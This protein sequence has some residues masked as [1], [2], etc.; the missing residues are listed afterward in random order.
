MIEPTPKIHQSNTPKAI[1]LLTSSLQTELFKKIDEGYLYW[2][3][4]KYLAPK[5]VAP[6]ILWHAVKLKRSMNQISLSIKGLTFHFTITGKMQQLL[7]EFDMEFGGNLGS[8]SIIPEKNQQVYLVNSIMEEAIA[9]SQME[10]ASTTRK[11][12]KDMLRKQTKP[13]GKS[14]QMIVNNYTTIKYLVEHKE[15]LFSIDS[16]LNVHRLISNKTLNSPAEEGTIRKDNEVRVVNDITGEVVHTPPSFN[17]L[18]DLLQGLCDFANATDNPPFIHPIIKG[19]IIHFMLAY[20]HPFSDGNGRTA[21]SLFYWYMLKEGYWLTEYI[22]ISRSIYKSKSQY[23]KSFLYAEQDD[24]DIS[25]FIKYHLD[26]MKK[27]Y[28]DLKG[29][30]QKKIKEQQEFYTFRAFSNINERQAEI[31]RIFTEK[32]QIILT[33]KECSNRFPVSVKTARADLQHL[34]QLGLLRETPINK[35]LFGYAKSSDFDEIFKSL[36][37]R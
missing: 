34:T 13:I 19:I 30:I 33:A 27:A 25:Y 24:L 9:S 4:V 10:G 16:L 2:D 32:P 31:I 11:F 22:A 7:H 5:D 37:N 3:K 1:K 35:R 29:Y 6:E 26:T 14:Q 17:H 36:T 18:G 23:E 28:N 20:F 15:E 21:R 8:N 12:A